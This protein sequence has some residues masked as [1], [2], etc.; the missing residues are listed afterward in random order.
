MSTSQSQT[1]PTS[2]GASPQAKATSQTTKRDSFTHE[3]RAKST[4]K[5]VSARQRNLMAWLSLLLCLTLA[6]PLLLPYIGT[7]ATWERREAEAILTARASYERL[8]E[9]ASDALVPYYDGEPQ[10]YKLPGLAWQQMSILAV[11]GTDLTTNST[12]W[13]LRSAAAGYA[14]L[15]I[16]G[17]FWAGYSIGGTR[18]ATMAGL[19]ALSIPVTTY[20]GRLASHSMPQTAWLAIAAGASLWAM[21]PFRPLPS[22]WRQASGW[23][24]AGLAMSLLLLTDG[25]KALIICI[26]SL[27]ALLLAC[28]N[29]AGHLLGLLAASFIA[30]ITFAPWAAYLYEHVDQPWQPW[31]EAF[32]LTSRQ[33]Q[34]VPTETLE[35]LPLLF[36]ILLPWSP[37]LLAAAVQPISRSTEGERG[38][39][40]LGWAWLLC[41]AGAVL[42]IPKARHAPDMLS[43]VPPACVLLA[44]LFDFYQKMV[45]VGRYPR[46]WRWFRWGVLAVIG[47]TA[48]AVP[49]GAFFHDRLVSE[50]WIDLPVIEPLEWYWAVL[51]T[52][53]MAGVMVVT[54][55]LA[56]RHHVIAYV[57]ASAIAT[58]SVYFAM[59]FPVAAGPLT[60]PPYQAISDAINQS[61][62]QQVYWALD[63]QPPATLVASLQVG[64]TRY[65]ADE[66]NT[67]INFSQPT[68]VTLPAT[69]AGQPLD[70][71]DQ[72]KHLL[73]LSDFRTLQVQRIARD[74]K[75][76]FALWK[77]WLPSE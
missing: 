7:P 56:R 62:T 51:M 23:L 74:D 57:S 75:A 49:W 11:A 30:M 27:L 43:L 20:F 46:T 65:E 9:H 53:G 5:N 28:P 44:L 45:D 13:A 63:Q 25:P 26:I 39:F 4:A 36:L 48:L 64:L 1:S 33:W 16:A 72:V 12:R 32:A 66:R 38:R 18:V 34:Q 41:V 47:I 77:V 71:P 69:Q 59:I 24:I 35:M 3:Y 40:A 58:I 37:W 6:L 61:D 19:I 29:R 14:L 73:N 8:R 17:V 21:R 22:L 2:A 42:L 55:L 50:R 31:V 15:M 10:T 52:V 70:T 54:G 67:V 68:L 60:H 76:N